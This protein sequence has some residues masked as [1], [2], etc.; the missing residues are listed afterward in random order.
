MNTTLTIILVLL[1]KKKLTINKLS[2]VARIQMLV[3]GFAFIL[4]L[5]AIILYLVNNPL[6]N[7]SYIYTICIIICSL[8]WIYSFYRNY[9]REKFFNKK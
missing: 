7:N 1:M 8:V 2:R 4:F 5:F 9:H 3:T 6:D